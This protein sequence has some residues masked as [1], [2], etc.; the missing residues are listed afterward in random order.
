MKRKT[1]L[2]SISILLLVTVSVIT[3]CVA[4]AQNP[5]NTSISMSANTMIDKNNTN[6]YQKPDIEDL[7]NY[8]EED[9]GIVNP[10]NPEIPGKE[11]LPNLEE[12][13]DNNEENNGTPDNDDVLETKPETPEDTTQNKPSDE[14]QKPTDTPKPENT[15]PPS[16]NNTESN[17][18]PV[19]KDLMFLINEKAIIKTKQIT[20]NVTTFEVDFRVFVINNSLSSKNILT[21]AFSA[22]YDIENVALYYQFLNNNNFSSYTLGAYESIDLSFT[23]K[24]V[25]YDHQNFDENENNNLDVSYMFEKIISLNI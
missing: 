19:I 14:T 9:S 7:P 24:F 20:G 25:V 11:D 12:S 16:N 1:I 5:S 3:F 18:N 2:V 8:D 22:E 4:T 21:N 23:L 10:D 13:P 6:I 15:I 17:K